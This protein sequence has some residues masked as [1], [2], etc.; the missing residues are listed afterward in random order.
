MKISNNTLL[1][2]SG[3]SINVLSNCFVAKNGV[4]MINKLDLGSLN[5]IFD[6]IFTAQQ[7]LSPNPDTSTNTGHTGQPIMY[8][9]LGTDITFLLLKPNYN[10]ANPQ[11]SCTTTGNTY[12]SNYIEYYY[13]DDPLTKRYLSEILILSGNKDKRIPQVYVYNPTQY[14]VDIDIMAANI[15]PNIISSNLSPNYVEVRGLSYNSIITDQAQLIS[16]YTGSTQFEILDINGN[17]Q[18]V[19]SY[20][21]INIITK[22]DSTLTLET[23]GSPISLIFNNDFQAY[24][25]LS[26]MEW[27]LKQKLMRYIIK[28]MALDTTAPIVTFNTLGNPTIL[29][30]TAPTYTI[31]KSDIIS[32]FI[33]TVYDYDDIGNGRDGQISNINLTLLIVNT[34]TS[35]IVTEITDDGS[36]ALT[37]TAKDIA[38]NTINHTKTLVVDSV[39]PNIFLNSGLTN[40]M[41]LT[42]STNT[43][44]TIEKDDIVRYYVNQV[45]DEVDGVIANSAITV[46]IVSG[47]TSYANI[48][49]PND[50]D[51]TFSVS[52]TAG[53]TGTSSVFLT[54]VDNYNPIIYYTSGISYN[55]I[56][57]SASTHPGYIYKDDI[58]NYYIDYIRDFYDGTI[59]NNLAVITISVL[60][61]DYPHIYETGSYDIN[62]GVT[63]SHSNVTNY[64]TI[65]T[66]I[67]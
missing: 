38:N 33:S 6:S 65:L 22:S 64:T 41:H 1:E 8:G 56:S 18:M 3:K 23:T 49:T 39:A 32:R 61:V 21:V 13:E 16:G 67:S 29:K 7:T 20:D 53:N 31:T 5:I 60:S 2:G 45:W 44:G 35:A 36:Y 54:V 51:I 15:N 11:C 14:D 12:S 47:V 52:D 9:F 25:A 28:T 58:N 46:S 30:R 57:L 4:N 40:I 59:S 50:Y 63:D 19:I 37:F 55:T 42:G 26:R 24:Q 17:T 48:T 34:T 62:I 43:P 66:V 27:V 10:L